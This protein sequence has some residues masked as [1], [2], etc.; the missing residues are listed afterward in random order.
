M[1]CSRCNAPLIPE[2]RFCR[3]C[4]MP[5]SP[6]I[7]QPAIASNAQANQREIGDSP[8]AQPPSWEVQQPAPVQ[9]QYA[10]PQIYQPTVAVSPNAGSMPSTGAPFVSPPL[11][12]RRRKNRL[13][14]VLLIF[15]AALLIIILLLVAGWFV[16]L[17][18]YLHGVAQNEI[19]GVFSSAIAQINPIEAVVISTSHAPVVITETDANTF[20]AMNTADPIQ[21]MHMTITQAGLRLDF[22]LYGF[23]ST[24]TGVPQAVNGQLVMTN[25]TVQGI[26]SSIMSPDELTSIV[27]ANLHQISTVL[28]RSISGV[29]LKDHEMDVQLR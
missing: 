29:I 10:P 9:P 18:P 5:V 11:S 19:N 3:N 4:G 8:T 1:N 2:A 13:T 14:Q 12:T 7:P 22:Q 27:N 15:L 24:V 16:V 28:P 26:A 21:Q 25:V 23:T 6:A 20:I 17:R